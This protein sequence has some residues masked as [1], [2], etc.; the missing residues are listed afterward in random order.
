MVLIVQQG[1]GE[2]FLEAQTEWVPMKYFLRICAVLLV[3]VVAW[4]ILDP[5]VMN[6]LFQ[7]DLR[8][9]SAQLGPR[10]GFSPPKSDDELR[11]I[12]LRK[13]E[14]RQIKLDPSQVMVQSSGPSDHRVVS[15]AVDYTVPVDLVLFSFR[16]HFA[17]SS[18]PR[19]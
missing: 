12:V 1:F 16:W 17:A 15:I 4:R 19:F 10:I 2:L 13:A 9:I 14:E 11:G 6:V 5:E 3:V 7:D 18:G 8:D